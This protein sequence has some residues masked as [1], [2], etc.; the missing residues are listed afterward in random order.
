M[1]FKDGTQISDVSTAKPFP[2]S[3]TMSA[4]DRLALDQA[5]QSYLNTVTYTPS[6]TTT[7]A[8]GRGIAINATVAGNVSVLMSGGG[9]F[10][11][12][13]AVG[14]TMLP[15]AV[16]R[17]NTTGSTATATYSKLT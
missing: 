10:V 15:L 16:T 5:N 13:V 11:F 2:T 8:A 9:T 12:P 7:I 17:V 4:S 6:D 14:L 1:A 3:S